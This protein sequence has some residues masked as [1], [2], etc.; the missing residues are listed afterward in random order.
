MRPRQ[1]GGAE[2]GNLNVELQRWMVPGADRPRDRNEVEERISGEEEV[3][4]PRVQ[5]AAGSSM[6][7]MKS[8]G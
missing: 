5:G 4:G 3:K 1:V 6:K 2:R 7:I 8:P